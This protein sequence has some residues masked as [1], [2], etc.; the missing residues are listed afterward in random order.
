M[1]QREEA[2]KG[3]GSELLGSRRILLVEV[4]NLAF[5]VGEV[6]CRFPGI[7]ALFVAFPFNSVLKLTTEYTGIR[8][9]VY[10]VLLFAFY[11]NWVRRWRFVKT[12]VPI[13]SEMVDMENGMKLQIVG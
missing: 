5:S 10:F 12:V 2:V 9:L 11:R 4:S 6:C 3:C 8:D 7:G 13:R 1:E